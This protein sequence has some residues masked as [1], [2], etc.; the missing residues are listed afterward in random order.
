MRTLHLRY[1]LLATAVAGE[2]TGGGAAAPATITLTQAQLDAA[3]QDGIAKAEKAK[4]PKR[5]KDDER[6]A[7]ISA[8]LRDSVVRDGDAVT[9]KEGVTQDSALD[10]LLALEA[11]GLP[12]AAMTYGKRRGMPADVDAGGWPITKHKGKLV[13]LNPFSDTH[14]KGSQ[15]AKVF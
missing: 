8:F 12:C 2:E 9:L 1:L 15:G 6:D 4:E 11:D 3:I 13:S 14:A 7:R 5:S 10:F